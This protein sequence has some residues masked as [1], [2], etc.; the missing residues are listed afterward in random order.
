[1]NSTNFLAR[2]ALMLL[3][4]L[5]GAGAACS[6]SPAATN[7]PAPAASANAATAPVASPTQNPEDL[8]PRVRA[9]EA[10][11]AV[12]KGSAVI[13]DVRGTDTYNTKHIKGALDHP[14]VRLESG[15]FK[16]LPKDKRLIAYCT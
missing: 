14:L 3:A 2:G 8:M 1:M 11:A 13:I 5:A 15:D 16:D 4:S 10:K 12:E 6:Q 9:E 7:P